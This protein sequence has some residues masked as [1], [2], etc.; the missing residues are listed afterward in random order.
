MSRLRAWQWGIAAL[1]GV[2]AIWLG[3]R[4]QH[5]RDI[6]WIAYDLR[7][8]ATASRFQ[9]SDDIVVV[10]IDE[11]SMERMAPAVGRWPWP[12][13][14]IA[15]ALDACRGAEV[16]AMDVLL[17]EPEL[18]AD[19]LDGDQ[20][21]AEVAGAAGPVVGAT[22]LTEAYF[23][24]PAPPE[25]GRFALEGAFGTDDV[26]AFPQAVLPYPALCSNLHQV[27]YVNFWRDPADAKAR[28]VKLTSPV[29]DHRLP[30]LA[31]A[32]WMAA[33]GIGADEVGADGAGELRAG[34]HRARADREGNLWI[35]WPAGDTP[36]TTIPFVDL[37]EDVGQPHRAPPTHGLDGRIVLVGMVASGVLRDLERTPLHTTLPGVMVHAAAIDNLRQG[38]SIRFPARG[39]SW[40]MVLVCSLAPAALGHF[41]TFRPWQLPVGF[42]L[43][44]GALTLCA[45]LPLW[46]GDLALPL[47]AP[48]LGL[49]LATSGIGTVTWASERQRRRR[50]ERLDR[51]KQRF[52]DMLVH[53]LKN[54]VTP[55]MFS[56]DLARQGSEQLSP[57]QFTYYVEQTYKQLLL[58]VNAIL[59]IR[60][61]EEGGLPLRRESCAPLEIVRDVARTY[62]APA[63]RLG[64]E[65]AIDEGD[66]AGQRLG[67]DPAIFRRVVENLVWNAIKY[68]ATGSRVELRCGTTD[69]GGGSGGGQAAYGITI[70]NA[71][72][73]IAPERLRQLFGE[74]VTGDNL[75]E[76]EHIPSTGLGLA[77]C[78]LAVE[79]H[80]G[81]IGIDS[82]IP[83][84]D[85]GFQAQVLLPCA[86]DE[87]KHGD[88]P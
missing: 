86:T 10:A 39:W 30:S 40:I 77:F 33:E 74:F 61:I 75:Q 54:T 5:L 45:Y 15:Y 83:G 29:G 23:D 3:E 59:D 42:L 14:V 88:S 27:G 2:V 58:Q 12:R 57:E 82:P 78:K 53:D 34:G 70:R 41:G 84:R 7:L 24:D 87:L 18:C 8:A 64:L 17:T 85:N 60:K 68:A 47:A 35:R 49:A 11:E 56:I 62:E 72:P 1:A 69:R 22:V 19:G 13:E 37:L 16:V 6:E 76:F 48:L 32:T 44:A 26:E 55:V 46:W 67:L 21:L 28:A 36:Y 81:S 80:G 63:E 50:L 79:A 73:P 52:T 65:V 66:A 51:A 4:S 43:L 31:L 71:C 25:L 20:L 9:A 38:R